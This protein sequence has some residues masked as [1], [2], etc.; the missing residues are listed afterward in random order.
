MQKI[1]EIVCENQ[2]KIK[3]I[4]TDI[5]QQLI[6]AP[7]KFP[8]YKNIWYQIIFLN[9]ALE[10]N[11]SSKNKV[12]NTNEKS[13]KFPICN[14]NLQHF[15]GGSFEAIPNEI[16]IHHIIPQ[17]MNSTDIIDYKKSLKGILGLK[18]SCRKFRSLITNIP[19]SGDFLMCHALDTAKKIM[20]D[21]SKYPNIRIILYQLKYIINNL[22]KFAEFFETHKDTLDWIRNSKIFINDLMHYSQ[23]EKKDTEIIDDDTIMIE[24]GTGQ[25]CCLDALQFASMYN[26]KEILKILIDIRVNLSDLYIDINRASDAL[27]DGEIQYTW[28]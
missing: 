10:N 7:S 13:P 11:R 4:I 23:Y 5:T 21:F 2:Q 22:E 9:D 25:E 14:M 27:M 17:I 6:S 24:F 20:N 12:S 26:L 8:N 15:N 3:Y 19:N 1:N 18:N 16:M 28:R